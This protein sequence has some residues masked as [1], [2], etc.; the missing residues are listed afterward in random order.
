VALLFQLLPVA[1]LAG[2]HT[3]TEVVILR[4]WRRRAA[5]RSASS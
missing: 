5:R 4:R 1:V 3:A 2:V